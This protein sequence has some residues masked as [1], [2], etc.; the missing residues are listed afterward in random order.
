[1]EDEPEILIKDGVADFEKLKKA[2]IS[3]DEL[4]ETVREH[5]VESVQHVKLAVLEVDGNISVISTDQNNR[6]NFS[7]HKRKFPRKAQRI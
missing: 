1:M 3:V 2:E 5:G 4:L 7:R 6:T